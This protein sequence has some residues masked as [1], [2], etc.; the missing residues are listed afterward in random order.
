MCPSLPLALCW[1]EGVSGEPP[2]IAVGRHKNTPRSK[3]SRGTQ[4]GTQTSTHTHAR[5]H[6]MLDKKKKITRSCAHIDPWMVHEFCD[7][8]PLCWLCLQEGSY[9][10]LSCK[11]IVY[12]VI[13]FIYIRTQAKVQ[14][15]GSVIFHS[16]IIITCC[17]LNV[18]KRS[19]SGRY[20]TPEIRDHFTCLRVET[21]RRETP[22]VV[23]ISQ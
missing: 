6:S 10:L 2:S 1:Y 9:Q 23:S 20:L 7:G 13:F 14:N 16:F 3:F 15:F 21:S 4:T 19:A 12:S 17:K 5:S 11:H 18:K 22:A 8:H